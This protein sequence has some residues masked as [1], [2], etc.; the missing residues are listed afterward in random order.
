[1]NKQTTIL[2]YNTQVVFSQSWNYFWCLTKHTIC[3]STIFEWLWRALTRYKSTILCIVMISIHCLTETSFLLDHLCH[4]HG[5]SLIWWP[6]LPI[7]FLFFTGTCSMFLGMC[8][9]IQLSF[10]GLLVMSS[11]HLCDMSWSG[12]L[13]IIILFSEI[14]ILIGKYHVL[15]MYYDETNHKWRLWWLPSSLV[16]GIL[17]KDINSWS[18]IW[19][20][21]MNS[22]GRPHF[23]VP[24]PAC[25]LFWLSRSG[26]ATLFVNVFTLF[27][28]VNIAAEGLSVEHAKVVLH[29]SC[30]D[31][32]LWPVRA[33][34]S[35]SAWCH[36]RKIKAQSSNISFATFQWKEKF[37]LWAL[38]FETAFENVTPSWIGC[39]MCK[40]FINNRKS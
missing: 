30:I 2:M 15:S 9:S 16:C 22:A 28:I 32:W 20:P 38:S 19:S 5:S 23:R 26:T 31:D 39:M 21:S 12:V 11:R 3:T 7:S 25:V 36:F 13:L 24:C 33:C 8:A 17:F 14:I 27:T 35:H 40:M 1:M 4:V 34:L 18:V 6:C 37:E 29:T 10:V